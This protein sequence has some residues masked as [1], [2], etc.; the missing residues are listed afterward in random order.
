[1]EWNPSLDPSAPKVWERVWSSGV[2][3]TDQPP[4]TWPTYQRRYFVEGWR[5]KLYPG[6]RID[7]PDP[8]S[9][10]P[11]TSTRVRAGRGSRHG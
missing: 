4:S 8:S 2:D 3:V 1:M 10:K 6:E 7:W 9:V 5:P 11:G